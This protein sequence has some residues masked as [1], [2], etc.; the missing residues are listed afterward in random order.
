MLLTKI[1]GGN[2]YAKSK[3]VQQ[4][5]D[6]IEKTKNKCGS[7]DHRKLQK[8]SEK[9]N[10]I[11]NFFLKSYRSGILTFCGYDVKVE[12][13]INSDNGKFGF[14]RFEN[15]EIKIHN[16]KS[17]HPNILKSV[18]IG[19][20]SWGLFLDQWTDGIVEGSFSKHEI[21]NQFNKKNIKIPE[22]FLLDFDNTILKKKIKRNEKEMK[23]LG[24]M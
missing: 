12:F 21:I 11:F 17:C 2:N 7:R 9:F 22:S 16:L 8:Y 5:L 23:R 10:E 1:H 19:K 3:L 24:L 14:R 4:R 6:R 18:I 13:D 20:K 15:G